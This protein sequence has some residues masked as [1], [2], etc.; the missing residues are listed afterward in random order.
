MSLPRKLLGGQSAFTVKLSGNLVDQN[1]LT[2]AL[3][4]GY[5]NQSEVNAIIDSTAVITASATSVP[6][7]ITGAFPA[8]T[9]LTIKCSG[10]IYGMYG[11]CAAIQTDGLPG[12]PALRVTSITGGEVALELL[13][14]GIYG[15]G[16]GGGAGQTRQLKS[17]GSTKVAYGGLGGHGAG[18]SVA[19]TAGAAGGAYA[20]DGAGGTGGTGG[21]YGKAGDPGSAG[22]SNTT[23]S[24]AGPWVGGAAGAAIENSAA[25]SF[26]NSGGAVAG[27]LA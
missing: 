12:G 9:R 13:A 3:A 5:S 6:G 22:W 19:L 11:V 8:G 27:L 20:G 10:K 7:L 14:G 25:L 21:D 26:I 15:G 23:Y 1:L 16:G 18:S 24:I 17:G 4:Q 2:A